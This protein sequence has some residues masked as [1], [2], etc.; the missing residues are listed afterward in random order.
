MT[1]LTRFKNLDKPVG[2]EGPWKACWPSAPLS[3]EGWSCVQ[4]RSSFGTRHLSC[5]DSRR[6]RKMAWLTCF[7]SFPCAPTQSWRLLSTHGT[8][9]CAQQVT[10]QL[11][12]HPV[13]Q[14]QHSLLITTPGGSIHADAWLYP[15]NL[16]TSSPCSWC[17]GAVLRKTMEAW[18][19]LP[20][21]R[22][23][24]SVVS[25]LLPQPILECIHTLS[26]AR[27]HICTPRL[28]IKPQPV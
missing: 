12:N 1:I 7:L 9:H 25:R 2:R 24:E 27:T 19:G 3:T 21:I 20:G 28:S 8:R 18:S 26:H 16:F 14:T 23:P 15:G 13:R 4:S 5:G 6:G 22:E 11:Y 17:R 10:L